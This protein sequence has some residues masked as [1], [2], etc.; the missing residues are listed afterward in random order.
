MPR[1]NAH[2]RLVANRGE[3]PIRI[4]RTAHE[5]SLH[6][7][8]IY[9][10]EDRLSMHR[11][12]ADEAYEI[13]QRGQYTPVGAYLAS[14]EIVKIAV[15][16][17]VNLIHPGYGFLSEN[18]EFAR[19]VEAAGLIVS[20]I[21]FVYPMTTCRRAPALLPCHLLSSD[22]RGSYPWRGCMPPSITLVSNMLL[23]C[24]LPPTL[25]Y[26]LV[27]WPIPRHHRCSR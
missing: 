6:T 3:I 14:D 7:V 12:K 15:E 13:G 18:A 2:C 20:R 23:F 4:F 1:P 8:A 5:L 22:A 21:F 9:S 17:G 27:R 10:H 24:P 25:T 11:Q 16:H 19:K 26:Y